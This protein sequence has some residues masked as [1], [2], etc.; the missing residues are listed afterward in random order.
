[1][2]NP[3]DPNYRTA[4]ETF[5]SNICHLVKAYGD[6]KFLIYILEK[7]KIR[8]Y[9][10]REYWPESFYLL[11]MVDYLSR[12]NDIPMCDEYD[13]IRER[14]LSETLYPTGILILCEAA[15]SEEPKLKSEREAIPE[16]RRFN[17]IE[18]RIRDVK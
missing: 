16:F 3:L 13:D 14:K 6:I 11:G 1:M 10:N 9:W 8:E 7:N 15:K 2:Y 17:I 5:K 18:S 4:F 12:V